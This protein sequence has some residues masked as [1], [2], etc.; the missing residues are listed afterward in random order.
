MTE[1][2]FFIHI[3]K[4]SGMT[5]DAKLKTLPAYARTSEG[6]LLDLLNAGS[7]PSSTIMG[8]H[9]LFSTVERFKIPFKYISVVR[10]PL[11]RVISYYNYIN[12]RGEADPQYVH[13]KDLSL[14]QF[15]NFIGPNEM[16]KFLLGEDFN[17]ISF[18]DAVSRIIDKYVFIG[19]TNNWEKTDKFLDRH[20]NIHAP[21]S[22]QN[23]GS[24]PKGKEISSAAIEAF[25]KANDLDY[26][27]YEWIGDGFFNYKLLNQ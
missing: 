25:K 12:Q 14:E 1:G 11:E 8:G 18:N 9:A 27:L 26:R 4:C 19:N 13:V 24:Y 2:I 5:V 15:I 20:F 10:D 22:R 17:V 16:S 7:R 6:Q 21:L 23:V 3:P